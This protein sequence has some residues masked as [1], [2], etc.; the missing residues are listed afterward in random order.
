MVS[1]STMQSGSRSGVSRKPSRFGAASRASRHVC[2]RPARRRLISAPSPP[3]SQGSRNRGPP[4]PFT[5]P[6]LPGSRL[7]DRRGRLGPGRRART[8]RRPGRPEGRACDRAARCRV[9]SPASPPCPTGCAR[10]ASRSRRGPR[11]SGSPLSGMSGPGCPMSFPPV[12]STPMRGRRP[13]R[14]V[15]APALSWAA[16]SARR[17]PRRSIPERAISRSRAKP[18]GTAWCCAPRLR[19]TSVRGAPAEGGP[20]S[21]PRRDTT[22]FLPDGQSRRPAIRWSAKIS[23]SG[24]W[25]S[26]GTPRFLRRPK[27]PTRSGRQKPAR[28]RRCPPVRIAGGVRRNIRGG[29]TLTP[30]RP[31]AGV[32]ALR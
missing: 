19:S 13:R 15:C 24:W 3:R 16:G 1:T 12:A 25:R 31:L 2:R 14:P 28:K 26:R 23:G 29:G 9:G 5:V 7:R 10:R 18:R 6:G 22:S 4:P 21:P 30:N 27:A 17:R 11:C 8:V 32:A 20:V